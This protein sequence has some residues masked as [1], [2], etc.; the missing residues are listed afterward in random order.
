ML[1]ALPV[2]TGCPRGTPL[3][4]PELGFLAAIAAEEE[5]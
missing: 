5:V 3:F 4:S 1:F 2:V